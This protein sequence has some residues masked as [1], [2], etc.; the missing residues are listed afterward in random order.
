MLRPAVASPPRVERQV[1]DLGDLRHL[2]VERACPPRSR[3]P[4]RRRARR[5][6]R[7]TSFRKSS[8]S[9]RSILSTASAPRNLLVHR[10][11]TAP[12]V[13]NSRQV[14]RMT[15][16]DVQ[17]PRVVA[18]SG[19]G[20]GIGQA[21]ARKFGEQGWQVVV[22]GRRVDRLTE[23]AVARRRSGRRLPRPRARRHRRRVR[24]AV[25]RRGR[26]PVRHRDR[27]DQQRRDRPLRTARR[28]L[29]RGDPRRGRN[30]AHRRAL[31]G[32]A[33]HPSHATRRRRRRHPLRHVLGRGAAL[34][35][36]SAVRGGQRRASSR[37]RA[38][39]A[40]SWRAPASA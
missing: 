20:T 37:R 12:L 19:A 24:R 18:I 4:A 15:E 26:G 17:R 10:S 8:S 13:S 35:V 39:C 16:P 11:P 21:T 27:G 22:G 38:R 34:A 3:A 31:H 1:A 5:A 29:A 2:L 23:T 25:L 9:T 33:R 32:S 36:P 6:S 30:Q 14:Y 28:L 40:W 7:R